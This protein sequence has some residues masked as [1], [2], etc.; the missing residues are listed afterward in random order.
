M[1]RL[2]HVLKFSLL[3]TTLLL[4]SLTH[5]VSGFTSILQKN[6]PNLYPP[7]SNNQSTT[8]G[9]CSCSS[10]HRDKRTISNASFKLTDSPTRLNLFSQEQQLEFWI[11]TFSTAHIGMSAVR[12]KI[13][14]GCGELA[15][16]ADLIDRGLTLPSYWPGK[17]V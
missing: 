16:K 11:T 3:T 1:Y 8:S 17:S 15:S 13:I 14:N 7:C 4:D 2:L 6:L 9:S 5:Q 10:F 12:D